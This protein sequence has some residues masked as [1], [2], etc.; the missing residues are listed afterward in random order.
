MN[1]RKAQA[2]VG[3]FST[4]IKIPID[5]GRDDFIEAGIDGSRMP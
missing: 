4:S 3:A 5:S 2:G 1:E